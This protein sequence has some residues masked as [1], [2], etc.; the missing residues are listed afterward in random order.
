MICPV[1]VHDLDP[2][3][4]ALSSEYKMI[5]DNAFGTDETTWAAASPS[6][7]DPRQ[8]ANR[9]A[10]GNAPRLILLDQSNDDQLVPM[11]QCDQLDKNMRQIEGMTIIRGIRARG[12]HALPWESGEILWNCVQ[13][14]MN[15]LKPLPSVGPR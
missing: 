13:D 15:A 6:R 10:E 4:E 2:A 11:N 9:L 5:L 14:A 3:H 8:I 12:Y 7:F 1:S